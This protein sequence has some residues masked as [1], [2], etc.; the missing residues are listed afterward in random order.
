M[1][2]ILSTALT[3]FTLLVLFQVQG[4]ANNEEDQIDR[5]TLETPSEPDSWGALGT[6]TI[7]GVHVSVATAACGDGDPEGV[8]FDLTTKNTTGEAVNVPVH[9]AMRS[10]NSSPMARMLP[11]PELQE[12]LT[13]QI[14]LGGDQ[15]TTQRVR[16][17]RPQTPYTQL[18]L[19]AMDTEPD[20]SDPYSG[21]ILAAAY[22]PFDET[23]MDW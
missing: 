18:S 21:Q 11:P 2:T 23:D 8:C 16:L 7:G 14:Q 1:R 17:T 5:L 4:I 19:Y 12:T 10:I 9:L 22:V 6:A 20:T 13:F 15:V 3:V